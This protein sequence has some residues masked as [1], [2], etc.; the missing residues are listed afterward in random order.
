MRTTR[1]KTILLRSLRKCSR[2]LNTPHL[3]IAP[4]RHV[5]IAIPKPI[6]HIRKRLPALRRHLATGNPNAAN[7]AV[8]RLMHFQRAGAT[9]TPITV[10]KLVRLS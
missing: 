4:R 2:V 7:T 5:N 9:I 3:Q 1:Q 10:T 6:S 8:L